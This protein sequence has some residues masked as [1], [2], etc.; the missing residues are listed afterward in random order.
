MDEGTTILCRCSDLDLDEIRRLIGEGYTSIDDI[1]RVARLG[2]GVC[3]GRTCIPLALQEISK[4]TGVP[5][6]EL[7]P[8]THR[9]IVKSIP[10]GALADY[11][12]QQER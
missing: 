3:Q 12:N 4:A 10:L 5:V 7:D 11:D 6:S 9:P 2:M 1:K 8:G